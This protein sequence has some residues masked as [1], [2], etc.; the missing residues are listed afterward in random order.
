MRADAC[1]NMY[2][3]IQVCAIIITPTRDSLARIKAGVKVVARTSETIKGASGFPSLTCYLF[4]LLREVELLLRQGARP[5]DSQL[6]DASEAVKFEL[7]EALAR[8]LTSSGAMVS[9]F[10]AL[11]FSLPRKRLIRANCGFSMGSC[12][13]KPAP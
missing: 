10:R 1:F 2:E 11:S 4:K 6:L 7:W 9:K 12:V 13:C 3:Q 8:F 5:F